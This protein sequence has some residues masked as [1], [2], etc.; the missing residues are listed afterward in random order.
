MTPLS[1]ADR[2]VTERVIQA[3][4]AAGLSKIEL[5]QKIGLSKQG[6]QA[7]ERYQVAFTV[8]QIVTIARVVGRSVEY[9]MGLDTGL[10]PDEEQ[11]LSYY[12][13]AREEGRGDI[14]LRTLAALSGDSSG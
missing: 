8:A 10:T 14:T 5:G 9:F 6:Y 13:A 1:D 4:E 3:R 12:R 2:A 7:Y 11:A